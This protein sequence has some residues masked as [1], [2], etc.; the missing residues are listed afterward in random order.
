M[1]AMDF[2]LGIANESTFGTPVTVSRFF[3]YESE[4][5]EESYGRTEGDPLR[6]GSAFKRGDRFTPYLEGV[7]GSVQMAVMTKGFGIWLRHLMGSVP[8]T[9]GPAETTVYT[10]TA[11]EGDLLGDSFTMQLNR[12][13][14]PAGTNQAFTMS[15][16]KVEE[17]TLSNSVDGNLLL[18]LK[19]DAV[20]VTTAT[21]LA[22]ASYPSGMENLTW[23]GGLITVGGTNIDVTEV[24]ITVNNGLKTDRRFIR[25][26]TAKKEQTG[27][28][29]EGSF[30]FKCDFESLAMRTYVASATAAGARATFTGTWRGPTLLGT[31]L[32]PEFTV[33]C[34]VGRF[35]EWKA[36]T[37]GPE[38]IEQELSGEIRYDGASSPLTLTYK[39]ADATA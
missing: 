9:S 11:G 2:Q 38:A 35:D 27:A 6:V 32:Y 22:T 31:T 19:V 28:R 15:G 34:P 12:P 3:E 10:H 29:R 14:H 18:D 4:S 33:S 8:S 7:S 13:F 36:A 37:G 21:A 16:C 20:S 23:A 25:Q 5:M 1:G 17:W 24:G 30:S 26:N 39:T